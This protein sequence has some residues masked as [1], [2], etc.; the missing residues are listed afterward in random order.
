MITLTFYVFIFIT[1]LK[2]PST[3]GSH[4]A[5]YTC[6]SHLTAITVFHGT[7]LI[8]SCVPNSKSSWLMIKM[9]SNIYTVFILMLNPLI[10]SV[11]NKDVKEIVKKLINTEL[12]CDKM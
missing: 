12:F 9:A 11:R 1:V 2:I 4:K 7:V 6:A 8:L 3:S 10:Y 5:F